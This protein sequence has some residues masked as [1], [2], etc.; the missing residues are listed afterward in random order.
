MEIHFTIPE[1]VLF[2]L[3]YMVLVAYIFLTGWFAA[4]VL[5]KAKV[6]VSLLLIPVFLLIMVLFPII[7]FHRFLCWLNHPKP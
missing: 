3:G 7:L 5:D 4:K 1:Q 6:A 2:F